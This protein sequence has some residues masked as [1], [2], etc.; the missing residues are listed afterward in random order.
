MH[1]TIVIYAL[2]QYVHNVIMDLFS[3]ML[4]L[5]VRNLHVMTQTVLPVHQMQTF[6]QIVLLDGM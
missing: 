3:T 6:A 1:T 4:V 5:G 2:K